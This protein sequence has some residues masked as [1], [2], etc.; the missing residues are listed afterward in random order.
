MLTHDQI[1]ATS[2]VALPTGEIIGSQDGFVTFQTVFTP[3]TVRT[4]YVNLLGASAMLYGVVDAIE[5]GLD[6]LVALLER[7]GADAVAAPVI[8]MIGSAKT[9]KAAAVEGM[10]SLADRSAPVTKK[11]GDDAK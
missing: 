8:A 5:V 1:L 11:D 6:E 7:E 10:R 3:N 9:A 4:E 2:L